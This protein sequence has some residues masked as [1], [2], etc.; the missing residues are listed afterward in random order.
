MCYK[1]VETKHGHC[2]H[3]TC[4]DPRGR[5]DAVVTI[6]EERYCMTDDRRRVSRGL[7]DPCIYNPTRVYQRSDFGVRGNNRSVTDRRGE[8]HVFKNWCDSCRR[9]FPEGV[10]DYEAQAYNGPRENSRVTSAN[11]GSSSDGV[12]SDQEEVSSRG[13]TRYAVTRG[14]GSEGEAGQDDASSQE[15]SRYD[16]TRGPGSEGEVGSYAGSIA[17]AEDEQVFSEGPFSGS[18]V[19]SVQESLDRQNAEM[20]R[21]NEYHDR[22][23]TVMQ[24]TK[25][26]VE[27]DARDALDEQRRNVHGDPS[28]PIPEEIMSDSEL[29][30]RDNRLGQANVMRGQL[31]EA[32]YPEYFAEPREELA[33]VGQAHD[34]RATKYVSADP[35]TDDE[36]ELGTPVIHPATGQRERRSHI[37]ALD[38]EDTPQPGE[39]YIDPNLHTH[40]QPGWDAVEEYRHGPRPGP[41]PRQHGRG[42]GRGRGY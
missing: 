16:V 2:V 15:G 29:A 20:A 19:A 12:D 4:C 40:Q 22:E 8:R 14:P 31:T 35:P 17:P 33:L 18:S 3:S 28:L 13:G 5:D 27:M 36:E 41:R 21:E 6:S 34:R 39:R 7:E 42:R 24:H 23:W 32:L 37:P 1:D 30:E 10:R 25:V 26:L 11:T 38:W 9:M